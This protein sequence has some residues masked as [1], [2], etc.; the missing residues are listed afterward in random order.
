MCPPYG[1]GCRDVT[2]RGLGC[3]SLREKWS[4]CGGRFVDPFRRAG[5]RPGWVT[6]HTASTG[7]TQVQQQGSLPVFVDATEQAISEQ[8]IVR[9]MAWLR[10]EVDRVPGWHP[11]NHEYR[12]QLESLSRRQRLG[13]VRLG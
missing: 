2:E 5:R 1:V 9:F 4:G 8:S 11:L 3:P 10:D 7:G 6:T 13:P 12:Q